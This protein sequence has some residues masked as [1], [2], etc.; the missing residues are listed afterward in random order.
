MFDALFDGIVGLVIDAINGLI[1]ALG[2]MIAA[3]VSVLPD[4]PDLPTMPAPFTTA[5]AWVSWFFPVSTVLDILAAVLAFWITWQLVVIAL[6][7]A[8]ASNS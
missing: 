2:S 4:M 5:Y 6:R 7:W 3:L 8:K 1:A